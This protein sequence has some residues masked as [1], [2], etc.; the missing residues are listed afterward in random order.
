MANQQAK[1]ER[2]TAL[3]YATEARA[4]C[5]EETPSV[6]QTMTMLTEGIVQALGKS[7]T[8]PE[9]TK[10]SAK[11]P[12][13][14]ILTDGQD[15]TFE[16]W[17]I[18][19]LAKLSVNADYFAND[20]ARIAYV[21]S[22]TSGDAQKHL[23]PQM[24]DN[25]VDRFRTAT[26]IIDHLS[27]IYKDPFRVQN[28][29]REYRRLTMTLYE[30]FADFYTR[31]LHLAGEG[32]IPEEDLRPDLYKKLTIELQRAIAP[33]EAT[34]ITLQEFQRALRRLDQN[35]RHIQ[36]RSSRLQTRTAPK[37]STSAFT[38]RYGAQKK[39]TERNQSER[40]LEVMQTPDRNRGLTPTSWRAR[41]PNL[42]YAPCNYVLY[43]PSS[44]QCYAC[45]QE[46]HYA[47]DCTA[48]TIK[49]EVALVHDSYEDSGL[50]ASESEEEL[51][52]EKPG[53]EQP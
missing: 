48:G 24:G 11:I 32:R 28:A 23:N 43:T 38:E 46:G 12:D 20:S 31:F 16:S 1:I 6:E 27:G 10:R 4:A 44:N 14:A 9:S 13:L 40:P 17:K 53:K 2:L 33:T 35:L 21:F 29:R 39:L 19:I 42:T 5:T 47:K 37:E 30:T 15:P 3:L 7:R 22:R 51:E 41:T 34:L 45:G 8:S 26:E 50:P 36:E 25:A 18:Q 49:P 52:I